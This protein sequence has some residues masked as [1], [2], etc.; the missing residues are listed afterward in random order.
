M[1]EAEGSLKDKLDPVIG[2][3]LRRR[4]HALIGLGVT[5]LGTVGALYQLPNRYTSEATLFVVE[6]Q[7]PQRYVT[8]TT[9]TELADA[10]PAMTQ[11]VL[12]RSRLLE[13][14]EQFDLYAPQRH[15]L[16][17]EE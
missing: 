15:R 2:V 13:L 1:T 4:W 3:I 17:P 11:Q 5:V 8:A 6:Q 9:T 14:V 12:S 7:V 16:A 10:L